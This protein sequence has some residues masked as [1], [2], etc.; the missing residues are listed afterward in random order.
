MDSTEK[1]RLGFMPLKWN[2]L[3]MVYFLICNYFLIL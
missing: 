2:L 3:L 1:N